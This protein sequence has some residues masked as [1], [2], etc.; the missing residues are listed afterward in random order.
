MSDQVLKKVSAIE[1]RIMQILR[2]AF[3]ELPEEG[4]QYALMRFRKLHRTHVV[5]PQITLELPDS[6]LEDERK[7]EFQQAVA[8]NVQNAARAMREKN[9]Y[10]LLIEIMQL[11][12]NLY[13]AKA[14][15]EELGV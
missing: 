5:Q 3:P 1:E 9:I 2:K 8:K 6:L 11:E 12:I 13:L 10:P 7:E 14:K 4:F 15:L